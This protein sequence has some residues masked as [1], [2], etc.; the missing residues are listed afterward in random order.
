MQVIPEITLAEE[1]DAPHSK[2]IKV[3]SDGAQ[4]DDEIPSNEDQDFAS[5]FFECFTNP[6]SRNI[7]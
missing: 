6:A 3:V 5:K 2:R 1:C 7:N 4:K